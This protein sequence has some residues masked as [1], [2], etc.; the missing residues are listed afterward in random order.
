MDASKETVLRELIGMCY[1]LVVDEGRKV[2]N[3]QEFYKKFLYEVATVELEFLKDDYGFII[4]RYKHPL[5]AI[6]EYIILMVKSNAYISL[7][8]LKIGVIE[9]DTVTLNQWKC[10]YRPNCARHTEIFCLRGFAQAYAV[11]T[12]SEGKFKDISVEKDPEGNCKIKLKIEYDGDLSKIPPD[13]KVEADI[14]RVLT[15]DENL[16]LS[17]NMWVAGIERAAI[18]LY[19]KTGGSEFLKKFYTR[20]VDKWIEKFFKIDYYV[21][22]PISLWTEGKFLFEK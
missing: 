10:E 1:D 14:F 3:P 15:K 19:G 2:K 11:D 13:E 7:D 18:K 22:I 17:I 8:A 21:G 12:M 6:K 5:S 4:P 9:N 20:L 16:N